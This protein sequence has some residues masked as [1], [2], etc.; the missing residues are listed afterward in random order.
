MDYLGDSGD[1]RMINEV[2]FYRCS[3]CDYMATNKFEKCPAC[4][5]D[6]ERVYVHPTPTQ[7]LEQASDTMWR[8]E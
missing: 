3:K 7:F 5:P 1:G 4:S 2:K 6:G 8:Q